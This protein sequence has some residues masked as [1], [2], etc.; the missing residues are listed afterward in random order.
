LCWEEAYPVPIID[1]H[2][3]NNW[4]G[5]IP[6][7]EDAETRARRYHAENAKEN[8]I[9]CGDVI[10]AKIPSIKCDLPE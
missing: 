9:R 7:A 5:S 3:R 6:V 2:D 4:L 1:R 8:E 10:L